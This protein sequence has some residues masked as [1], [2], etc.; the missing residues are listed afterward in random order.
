MD[1]SL[2]VAIVAAMLN[3]ILSFIVPVLLKNST[4][5]FTD[6]ISEHYEVNRETI[7]V[8]TVITLIFVY[9]SLKITPFVNEQ[10]FA[11]LAKLVASQ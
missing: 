2:I 8:S 10:V 4:V 9:V 5:P 7:I 6:E 1:P 3:L 11:R